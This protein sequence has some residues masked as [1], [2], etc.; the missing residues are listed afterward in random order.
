METADAIVTT[1]KEQMAEEAAAFHKA[2]PEVWTMFVLFTRDRIQRG[3]KAYSSDAIFHRIRWETA[4]P[5]YAPGE[6]FKLNDHH[7]A[8]YARRFMRMYPEFAGFFRTRKQLSE[9]Q[10]ASTLPPLTPDDFPTWP[11]PPRQIAP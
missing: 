2:H 7:T 4:K 5:T 8:F 9:N 3:F 6:E 1:R 11:Q 10:P